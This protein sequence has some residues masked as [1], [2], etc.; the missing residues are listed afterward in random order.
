MGYDQAVITKLVPGGQMEAAGFLPGDIVLDIDGDGIKLN[1]EISTHFQFSPLSDKS[2]DITV[3]RNG[4]E[5]TKTV[6]P[7]LEQGEDGTKSYKLGFYYGAAKRVK[8]GPLETLKYSVYEVKYW[9]ET[10]VKSVGSLIRGQVLKDDIAGPVGIVSI[11]GDTVDTT[12]EESKKAG[13][14]ENVVKN[15][16]LTL[17]NFCILLSANLGVMNLLPIPALDG[18]RLLFLIIEWIRRK[19]LNPKFEGVV[20]FA[21]FAALMLLMIFV[22]FNDII[23]LF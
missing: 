17:I 13:D 23:K 18:G 12:V 11:V 19:P 16:F 6:T 14:E 7:A 10:T 21:G 9:I 2:L 5:I 8:T 22:M 20:N 3:L 15:V 1:R 4:K